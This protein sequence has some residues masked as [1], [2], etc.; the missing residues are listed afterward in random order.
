MQQETTILQGAVQNKI[1]CLFKTQAIITNPKYNAVSIVATKE[2][3]EPM[4]ADEWVATEKVDGTCCLVRNGKLWKRFDKKLNKNGD[5][6]RKQH[7]KLLAL[8]HQADETTRGM[9]PSISY[10]ATDFKEAPATWVC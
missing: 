6:K 5:K 10:D 7:V 8:W 2:L 4:N 3:K 9:A 1:S